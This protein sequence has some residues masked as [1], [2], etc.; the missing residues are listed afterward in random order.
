MGVATLG[1]PPLT[2]PQALVPNPGPLC[3]RPRAHPSAFACHLLF[4]ASLYPMLRTPSSKPLEPLCEGLAP[5]ITRLCALLYRI[6]RYL[7]GF[8]SGLVLGTVPEYKWF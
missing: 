4:G 5:Y 3:P 6:L 1:K 2:L 7:V 8:V